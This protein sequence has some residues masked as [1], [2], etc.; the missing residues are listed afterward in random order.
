MTDIAFTTFL[1][2]KLLRVVCTRFAI[3]ENG[4]YKAQQSTCLRAILG[5]AS[6]CSLVQR[7][8]TGIGLL[9]FF[10]LVCTCLLLES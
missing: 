3:V 10:L 8:L 1:G 4:I 7:E 9:G 2:V 6:S 5:A